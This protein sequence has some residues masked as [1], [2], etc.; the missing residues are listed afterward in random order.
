MSHEEHEI[1]TMKLNLV[2]FKFE[3]APSDYPND[4]SVLHNSMSVNDIINELKVENIELMRVTRLN[5]EYSGIIRPIEIVVKEEK[6]ET[7]SS[8]ELKS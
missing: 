4:Q 7:G 6:N 1:S 3:E 5:K 8:I 2:A